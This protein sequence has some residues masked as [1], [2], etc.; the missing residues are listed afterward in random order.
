MNNLIQPKADRSGESRSAQVV[1]S[2]P[3]SALES[4]L[5]ELRVRGR[6]PGSLASA[7]LG[8]AL[9]ALWQNRTRS[10]LTGLGIFIGV[11]AV[12]A[13]LTLTQGA[14]SFVTNQIASLGTNSIIIFPGA[15]RVRGVA[16]NTGTGKM[17]TPQDAQLLKNIP[18]V[19]G[20]SPIVTVAGIQAVYGHQNWNTQVQ[21]VSTDYQSI[22][23]WQM[24]EGMWFSSA[25]DGSG[26]PVALLGDTVAH[27]L[28]D[29]TG[30]DPIGRTIRLRDQ[31]FRVVGVLTPKGGGL[32][33][34]DV[35]FIP[36]KTAQTRLRNTTTVDQIQVQV[37][38]AENIALAQQS[39]TA[40]LEQSHHL[41]KG[42][43]DDFQTITSTQ[44]LQRAQQATQVLT[45]LLV[46][47]AG[48]SLT[49]GGIGIMNIMLVSVTERTREIGLR[50]SIG[51]RRSDIRNQFLI[52]ALAL[53]LTGGLIG[54]ILGLLIGLIATN[55]AGLPFVVTTTTL[56]VPFAVS[57]G[58][59]IIFG[60]YPAMQA[61]RLD[62][63]V[64]L[65]SED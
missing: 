26:E 8:S 47:I 62:P 12:I 46:G 45:I 32:N 41:L 21:G 16:Q 57:V 3:A 61:A 18:H 50:I 35:I 20:V 29:A 59:G 22:Q 44:I 43:T 36:L 38:S 2:A 23:N 40:S 63:I 30:T 34:D 13:A 1:S 27:S 53:C 39:I 9:D 4:M 56:V 52:E 6:K 19:T 33:Q 49:V 14:S 11:A 42:A 5:L 31:L 54:L 17:L 7:N 28:F 65:R 48:I 25:D 51:A 55:A 37:D 10:L 24:A 60:L 15:P 64:A 58:I